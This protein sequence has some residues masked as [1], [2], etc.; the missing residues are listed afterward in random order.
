MVIC[1][2]FKEK[3]HDQTYGLLLPSVKIEIKIIVCK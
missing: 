1:Q 2:H 3:R